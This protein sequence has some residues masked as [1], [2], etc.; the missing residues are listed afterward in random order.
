MK[1]V[2]AFEGMD[3]AGKS[4]LAS[5][6]RRLC[7]DSNQ[8]CTLVGRRG[9]Y[10]DP[11]VARLTK[12]LQEGATQLT[13]HADI[14]VRVARE[15]QRAYLAA[16]APADVVVLDRFV[17]SILSLA[18]IQGHEIKPVH[19]LLK[20]VAARAHLFATVFVHC[21]FETA[22]ERVQE[23]TAGL[24]SRGQ[25]SQRFLRRLAELLEDDFERGLLTGQQWPVD[26]SHSLEEAQEQLAAYLLPHLRK[27]AGQPTAPAK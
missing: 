18:R 20:D 4:S 1:I 25:K 26:N 6:T 2:L 12:L 24:L 5:F 11:V 17:L 10:A 3:G 7:Q 13:P 21:P 14:S 27:D 15:Y 23:R 8:S 9:T 19:G 16:S 22:S